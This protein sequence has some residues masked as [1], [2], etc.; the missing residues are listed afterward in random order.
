M[1]VEKRGIP[2]SVIF[3]DYNQSASTPIFG[4]AALYILGWPV[5]S[6]FVKDIMD[7]REFRRLGICTRPNSYVTAAGNVHNKRTAP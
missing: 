3:P 4:I 6:R 1:I 5:G 2:T 7:G